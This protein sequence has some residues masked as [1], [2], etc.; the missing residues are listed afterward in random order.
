M[1]RYLSS[2]LFLSI[3]ALIGIGLVQVYSS[4]FIFA[5]ESYGDGLFFFK[6]QLLFALLAFAILICTI[7]MTFK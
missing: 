2:S 6:K 3:I 4:S 7:Q 5:I 1:L